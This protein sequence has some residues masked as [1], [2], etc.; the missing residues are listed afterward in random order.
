MAVTN[1]PRFSLKQYSSGGDPHPTRDEHNAM[2]QAIETQAARYAG[3]ATA[4]RP[5]AGKS[6]TFYRDTEAKRVYLDDGGAWVDISTNGGGGAGADVVVGGTAAE[7]TSDRGARADHTHSLALATSTASG[8]MPS[9]DKAKLDAATATSTAG[10]LVVRDAAGRARFA[11]PAAAADVAS[12]NYVDVAVATRAPSSHT[13]TAS[14]IN[15]GT[16]SAARLPLVSSTTAGA[17]SSADKVLLDAATSAATAGT[18]AERDSAGRLAVADPSLAGDASTKGYVDQQVAT[19]APSSHTHPWTDVTGK[20]ATYAPSAHGHAWS[21]ISG[22]PA[23]YAPSAHKHP[24]TDLT[25]VPATFAPSAHT[26]AYSE[27]TGV[28]S[29]FAPSAHAH[30]WADVASGRPSWIGASKPSYAATEI[31]TTSGNVQSDISWLSNENVARLNGINSKVSNSEY[32]SRI[33]GDANGSSLRVPSN[34]NAFIYV[35]NDTRFNSAGIYNTSVSYGSYRA[36]WVNDGGWVGYNLSSRKYKT[37]ERPYEV[38]LDLL[39]TIEPKWFK[40]R[41]DV[42]ELGLDEAPERV[43][44]IAEDLH[45]AGLREFVSYDDPA[46]TRESVETINEQLMVAALWSFA[47]QQQEQI[48][49]LRALLGGR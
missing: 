23:T 42:E 22:A 35:G 33:G 26:H 45:D 41:T 44:F 16:L 34:G 9:G 17:M 27:L 31:S 25:G 18:I 8:A 30:V 4:A 3:G 7:G 43:N 14:D 38:S 11:E 47:R 5:A 46:R 2:I 12:R 48:D 28:P 39:R 13:H 37:A 6:G 21:E 19:R 10:A 32:L 49:E 15:S 29:T 20:P 40:Y 36:V 24:W 1:T